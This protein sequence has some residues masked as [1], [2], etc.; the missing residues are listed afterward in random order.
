MLTL[1]LAV[2]AVPGFADGDSEDVEFTGVVESIGGQNWV[3]AGNTVVVTP[4]TEIDED[5]GQIAVGSC[6]SVEGEPLGDGS[7]LAEEIEAED[8]EEC[9]LPPG[10][11]VGAGQ[12]V[13]F[14][15]QIESISGGTWMIAGRTVI[16]DADTELEEDEGPLDEGACAS[17][18]GVRQSDGSV[19][20][21]EIES[22]EPEEC[23]LGGPDVEEVEFTGTIES[24][25]GDMWVIAGRTVRTDDETEFDAD[26][27]VL[28]VGGCASVEGTLLANG[29][30][31]AD[32]I[33]AEDPE[34]CGGGSPGGPGGAGREIEFEGPVESISP[35][36]WVVAGRNVVIDTETEFDDDPI[37]VGSCVS[38]EGV[39]LTSGDVLAREIELEDDDDCGGGPT[40][41]VDGNKIHFH[42]LLESRPAAQTLGIWDVGGVLLRVTGTTELDTEEG[43]FVPGAC[44]EVE[45][46]STGAEPYLALEL[47][48]EDASE[49][50]HDTEVEFF[51]V[52]ESKPEGRVGDWSVDGMRVVVRGTTEFDLDRG[53]V[54]LGAC[55][56]IEGFALADGSVEA[57]EIEV[58]SSSGGCDDDPDDDEDDVE[59]SGFVEEIPDTPGFVGDWVVAGRMVVVD[60]Q[61]DI[62]V[63]RPR[64]GS[65]VEV[66]GEIR[67]SGVVADEIDSSDSCRAGTPS[68][69]FEFKGLLEQLPSEATLIGDWVVGGRT[70]LVLDTTELDTEEGPFALGGCVEVE[71]EVSPDGTLTAREIETEE[72]DDCTDDDADDS[73]LEFTGVAESGPS[74]GVEGGWVVSGRAVVVTADTQIDEDDGAFALGSCVEVKGDFGSDGLFLA[75]EID[76]ES[77]SGSCLVDDG[78][79]NA[80]SLADGE[81]SPGQLVS[82]FGLGL[83]PDTPKS[84]SGGAAFLPKRLGGVRVLFDG[85]PAPLLF[86][87]KEQIN[88]VAPSRLGDDGEADV[89]V[90]F[91]SSWSNVLTVA[92]AQASPGIFTL[93]Q[94]GAGQAAALNFDS[95]AYSVNGAGNPIAKGDVLIVYFTGAGAVPVDGLIPSAPR[96]LEGADVRVTVGGQSAEVLY[97]GDAPGIVS[98]VYQA[99][100]RIPAGTPAGANVDLTITVDGAGTQG[101]VT[102]AVQ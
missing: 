42:G 64:V 98:G 49:C 35:E 22:E 30:V 101:G 91:A 25:A 16:V 4:E 31:L 36:A 5:D 26:D 62:D 52:V 40:P 44:V 78:L 23:G 10:T 92:V 87:S 34:E 54:A 18:E 27:G 73:Y 93:R 43:A 94:G 95:G 90:E 50:R 7:I 65:C 61:T 100:I 63:L 55:V 88:L 19:L 17:V 71:G 99:N 84:A 76:V 13:E 33:E 21:D 77:A 11:G 14:T 12:E 68:N 38:V 3:V 57:T 39:L 8:P 59:F 74:S 45:A 24:I 89:Q 86:V 53:P 60:R 2:S 9:G 48:T 56:S 46:L 15:G 102:I 41:G 66:D 85:Q 47:E 32:E 20:A 51:G 70:V 28:D 97:V 6:V 1:A 82:L 80:A 81:I 96:A 67:D 58:I 37:V 29:D 75:A 79:R 72:Q 69:E 83:G